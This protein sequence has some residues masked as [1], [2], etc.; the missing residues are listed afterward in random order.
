MSLF[1][2]PSTRIWN[3]DPYFGVWDKPCKHITTTKYTLLLFGLGFR[4]PPKQINKVLGGG[5]T[6]VSHIL[7]HPR[8]WTI[9]N[10][11]KQSHCALLKMTSSCPYSRALQFPSL[12]NGRTHLNYLYLKREALQRAGPI[13]IYAHFVAVQSPRTMNIVAKFLRFHLCGQ[14]LYARLVKWR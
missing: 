8:L 5:A 13:I 6:Q 2:S 4:P 14:W 10:C 1:V 11:H 3:F 12:G 7:V 9:F